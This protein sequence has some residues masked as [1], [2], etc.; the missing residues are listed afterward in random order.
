MRRDAICTAFL[1]WSSIVP[2]SPF[3][4]NAWPPMA[5]R[6]IGWGSIIAPW[7]YCGRNI[8]R[9]RSFG[10]A[11][12][13]VSSCRAPGLRLVGRRRL[14]V[15]VEDPGV[16]L[17]A[18]LGGEG[19]RLQA[20]GRVVAEAGQGLHRPL[21]GL[22]L[23]VLLA[24]GHAGR[25]DVDEGEAREADRLLD[26]RARGPACRPGCPGRRSSP[27]SRARRAAGSP[28]PRGCP[29]SRTR[30]GGPR[31]EVGDSWPLVRP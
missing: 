31:G 9:M 20:V 10:R 19:H 13:F 23:L 1:S 14:R 27:R 6:T 24:V 2:C 28:G 3:C 4:M 11:W 29:R 22:Q 15:A 18:V 21:V 16:E 30:S 17:V 5:T 12:A 26:H 8:S 7:A 25:L